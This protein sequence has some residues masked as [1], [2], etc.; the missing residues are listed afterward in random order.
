MG[1]T[2]GSNAAKAGLIEN[3]KLTDKLSVWFN[4]TEKPAVIGVT[5]SGK[6]KLIQYIPVLNVDKNIP[7]IVL[8]N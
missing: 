3:M 5:D 1:L 7:Q 2:A 4:N 8:D 6:E